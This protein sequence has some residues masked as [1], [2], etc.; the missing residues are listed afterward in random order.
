M[1]S[2]LLENSHELRRLSVEACCDP[3]TVVRFLKG[4]RVQSTTRVRI[5]AA[6]KRAARRDR[7]S[8]AA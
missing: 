4:Q 7:S 2:K 5:E 8:E 3:R 6:L 1:E